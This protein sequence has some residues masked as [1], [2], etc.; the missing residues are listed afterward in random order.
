MSLVA[1][2]VKYCA[3]AQTTKELFGKLVY[4]SMHILQGTPYTAFI[5]S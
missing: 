1:M 3:M 2:L 5:K 4:D